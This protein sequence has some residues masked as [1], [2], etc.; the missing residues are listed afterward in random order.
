M[1]NTAIR[2]IAIHVTKAF[3]FHNVVWMQVFAHDVMM[4]KV[5]IVA[6][7]SQPCFFRAS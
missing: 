3:F 6:F 5:S 2:Y 1:L 7:F 4:E